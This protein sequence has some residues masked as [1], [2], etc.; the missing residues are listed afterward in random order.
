MSISQTGGDSIELSRERGGRPILEGG[1]WAGFQYYRN[2]ITG[3]TFLIMFDSKWTIVLIVF[4][5]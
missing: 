5:I 4:E 3:A 2:R 1:I